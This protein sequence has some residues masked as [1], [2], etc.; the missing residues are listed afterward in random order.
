MSA[1]SLLVIAPLIVM[2]GACSSTRQTAQAL[3][4]RGDQE[5][6]ARRYSA[7][8]IEYRN[9]IKKEPRKAEAHRKLAD[10]YVE[11]GKLEEAFRSYSNAIDL[12]AADTHSRVEAGRLLLGAGRFSEALIRAE[13]ALER[14]DGNVDAQILAGRALTG[15]RRPDEAIAQLDAAVAVDHRPSAY[16]ALA[17]VSSAVIARDAAS[18]KTSLNGLPD[19]H[20]AALFLPVLIVRGK[21]YTYTVDS[22]L[23]DEL[24]STD[25]MFVRLPATDDSEYSVVAVM[26]DAC[27]K[28]V[29]TA[30]HADARRFTTHCLSHSYRLAH[31]IQFSAKDMARRLEEMDE[32]DAV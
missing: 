28:S 24:A 23:K 10:V 29:F 27:A 16:A 26:T 2:A 5:L 11:Q 13:Q 14:Q 17:Q 6:A 15:L 21:L 3:V 4:Q 19:F 25:A 32:D 18:H 30:A 20:T 9:A 12:D 8:A 22:T 7:A 1:R 31:S